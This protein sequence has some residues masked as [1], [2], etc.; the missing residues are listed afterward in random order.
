MAE[1]VPAAL[2]RLPAIPLSHSAALLEHGFCVVKQ[3]VSEELLAKAVRSIRN[4]PLL[5]PVSLCITRHASIQNSLLLQEVAVSRLLAVE[6][7]AAGSEFRQEAGVGRLAALVGKDPVFERLITD[8]GVLSYV[9]A[10]LGASRLKLSS[11]NARVVPSLASASAGDEGGGPEESSSSGLQPLHA[12]FSAVAD[13][14]GPW[15]ANVLIALAPCKKR[16]Q[17]LLACGYVGFP[18][19]SR[20][21]V[22][23]LPQRARCVRCQA[24]TSGGAYPR[25]VRH[26]CVPT[27]NSG[28]FSEKILAQEDMTDPTAPHPDETFI[29]ASRGDC[30]IMNAH[31]WHGGTPNLSPAGGKGKGA[32]HLFWCRRDKPQQQHQKL[33]VDAEAAANMGE[34]RM[35]AIHCRF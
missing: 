9:A 17:P 27:F 31:T 5:L 2:G 14:D 28:T 24:P 10:V 26:L 12:D 3:L 20:L 15:V 7:D 11:V 16:K 35:Q 1:P 8:E 6:G 29:T 18:D 19:R 34:V 25:C 30:I 33:L 21:C 32:V 23:I 4:D 13:D 22:Q